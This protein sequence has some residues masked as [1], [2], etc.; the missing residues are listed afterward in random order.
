M[1][2]HGKTITNSQSVGERQVKPR[3]GGGR[4][5]RTKDMSTVLQNIYVGAVIKSEVQSVGVQLNIK[6][7]KKNNR[8]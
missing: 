1:R 4:G 7:Y 8:H 2:I 6:K 3:A 5:V